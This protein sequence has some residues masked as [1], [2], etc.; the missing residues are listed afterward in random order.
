MREITKDA[1]SCVEGTER[2][3]EGE[4]SASILHGSGCLASTFLPKG[5]TGGD[6]AGLA[7]R[8]R[9]LRRRYVSIR[10]SRVWVVDDDPSVRSHLADLLLERGY[11]VQCLDSGEQVLHSLT[12]SPLPA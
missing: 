11:D 3:V 10:R 6:V 1:L 9:N 7:D 4:E 5:S 2:L 12:N 8:H